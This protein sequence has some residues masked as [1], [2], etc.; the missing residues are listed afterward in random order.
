MGET[1][2]RIH[3]GDPREA[4]AERAKTTIGRFW[5]FFENVPLWA[6]DEWKTMETEEIAAFFREAA[7]A[8]K[9][10]II[11][12]H[13]AKPWLVRKWLEMRGWKAPTNEFVI[14]EI[15]KKCERLAA[16]MAETQHRPFYAGSDMSYLITKPRAVAWILGTPT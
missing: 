9:Q 13:N 8:L 2:Y 4:V 16:W 1:G 7:E 5:N 11:D 14:E 3:I 6:G 10:Q 15:R 12:T